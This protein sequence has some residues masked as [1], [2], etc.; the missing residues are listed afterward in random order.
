MTA[1][2][3]IACIIAFFALLFCFSITVYVKITDQVRFFLGAFGFKKEISFDE[4]D[5]EKPVK[6]KK[7]SSDKP[8]K[9]SQ[10]EKKPTK[11]SFSDSIEAAMLILKSVIRPAAKLLKHIRLEIVKLN[12]TVC[13]DSADELAI[14][15]GAI[16][17]AIYALLGHLKQL[18]HVK[19]N[20]KKMCIR[21]DF[22]G[23]LPEYDI[24]FKVKLRFG[25]IIS[26]AAGMIFGVLVN[27]IKAR[28]QTMQ[29]EQASKSD[30][31]GRD[32]S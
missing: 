13:G 27:T 25:C 8:A 23:D 17:T 20:N 3:V 5:K 10:P 15:Y 4:K 14:E 16:C 6:K 21:A 2:I 24:Y 11:E 29:P 26:S 7:K 9:K 19:L 1:L 30:T 31:D 32:S 22:V 12:M 28:N 18:I